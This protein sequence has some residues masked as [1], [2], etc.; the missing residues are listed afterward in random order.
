VTGLRGVT[1]RKPAPGIPVTQVRVVELVSDQG[2]I[3]VTSEG[4]AL[5]RA[6]DPGQTGN[7][8]CDPG[9]SQAKDPGQTGDRG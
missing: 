9:Q 4:C 1:S 3:P 8:A 7:Q 5:G 6:G 2:V